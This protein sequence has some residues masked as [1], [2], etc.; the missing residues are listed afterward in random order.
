MRSVFLVEGPLLSYH[1]NVR[2]ESYSSYASYKQAIRLIA[3]VARI[4][5]TCPRGVRLQIYP[6]W[7]RSARLDLSNVVKAIEDGLWRADHN[8]FTL[9]ARHIPFFGKEFVRVVVKW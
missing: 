5:P 4:P 2:G 9:Y 8:I 1:A 7:K 3:N 6:H